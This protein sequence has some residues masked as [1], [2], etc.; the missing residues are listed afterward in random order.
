MKLLSI[1]RGTF[2]KRTKQL[3]YLNFCV[4]LALNREKDKGLTFAVGMWSL[5][6]GLDV[7]VFDTLLLLLQLV[8]CQLPPAPQR[9]F[10][11]PEA[12]ATD[13]QQTQVSTGGTEA[14]LRTPAAFK[15]SPG[16]SF[17]QVGNF[18]V[19]FIELIFQP[20]H[21]APLANALSA[22]TRA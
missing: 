2:K 5:P 22:Q 4:W 7:V 14:S 15:H 19:I 20:Q 18:L 3:N 16:C 10:T 1:L 17:H 12:I 21:S 11:H 9:C 6:I 13:T 8:Q